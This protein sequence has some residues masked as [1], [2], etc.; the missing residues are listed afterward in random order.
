M[1]VKFLPQNVELEIEPGQSVMEL[2]HQNG[3]AIKSVCKGVPSCAEC[4]VRVVEGEHNV[5]P[6]SQKEL[7]LI[8]TGYFIDQRRLSCQLY[9]FG[10]I[11]VDLT[12]QIEKMQA[13]QKRPQG[14]SSKKE[15]EQS[16]AVT[17]NLIEE[18]E[19]IKKVAS[20]MKEEDSDK[21]KPSKKRHRYRPKNN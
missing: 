12:E 1:K 15:S 4:R 5:L 20:Q 10:D 19:E 21:E 3:I 14:H 7:S 16:F 13:S 8:G 17:G 9:C 6:P 2:A 11:T 18:D